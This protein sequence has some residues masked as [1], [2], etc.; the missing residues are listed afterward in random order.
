MQASYSLFRQRENT[1]TAAVR[2]ACIS[3]LRI[4]ANSDGSRLSNQELLSSSNTLNNN[5]ICIGIE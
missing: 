1:E 3:T 5:V 4:D 2:L